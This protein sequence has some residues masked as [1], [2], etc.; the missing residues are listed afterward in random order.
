VTHRYRAPGEEGIL[1]FPPEAEIGPQ[2]AR[3]RARLDRADVLIDDVPLP[4]FRREAIAEVLEAAR[5]YLRECGEPVPAGPDGPVLMSGHQPELTH[6]GVL[7]KT[8]A[9][10]GMAERHGLTPLNLIVDNDTTKNTSLRF[11][12]LNRTSPRWDPAGVHLQSVPYDRYEGEVTYEQRRVLDPGLFHSFVG[13]TQPLMRDWGFEPLLPEMWAEMYRQHN[14]TPIL[15]EIVSATRRAYERR[16][17]CRNL[18]IP[19]SRLCATSAFQR[20]VRHVARDL[21]R[22]H[23][24]Y[25]DSVAE[26]RVR[27]RVRSRNHPVPDLTRDGDVYEA[28]F[29]RMRAGG[30]RRARLMLKEGDIPEGPDLRSRALTTTMFLRL[31]LS[32]GFIHG[33]GGAKYD[34]VTDAIVERWLGLTPP[35][36]IVVT[37]TFRLPLPTFPTTPADVKAAERLVRDLDWNPQRYSGVEAGALVELKEKLMKQDPTGNAERKTWFRQLA[38]VTQQLRPHV[39]SET[40]AAK[41]HLTHRLREA[42]ANE[43]LIRRDFAWC[44]FPEDLLKRFCQKVR[45]GSAE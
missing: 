32:D 15:G 14:R 8:F 5:T 40:E 26:Y 44:L 24:I 6:V 11:A 22:F 25:N 34:E 12:V 16:W 28:P 13:R 1:S 9:L 42:R 41:T 43:A 20:F 37:A 39:G 45:G 23:R 21:P 10:N 18:E 36:I 31:I 38:S 35:E 4:R 27:N 30:E 33:I 2:L 3:N 17:G 7:V 29:W 19:L